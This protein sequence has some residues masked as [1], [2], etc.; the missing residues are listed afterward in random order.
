MYTKWKKLKNTKF[1]ELHPHPP[2][3][4][5]GGNFCPSWCSKVGWGSKKCIPYYVLYF[6]NFWCVGNYI[7]RSNLVF[8]ENI[9]NFQKVPTCK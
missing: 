4:Y 9:Q 1:E 6:F 3:A 2:L 8:D 5:N 7:D